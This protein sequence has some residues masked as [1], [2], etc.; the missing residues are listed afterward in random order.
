MR[1]ITVL[2]LLLICLVGLF[3]VTNSPNSAS[4]GFQTM[5]KGLKDIK[6]SW[7]GIDRKITVY[8][9]MGEV[10]YEFEGEF[11]IDTDKAGRIVFDADN[12]RIITNM[13]YI[14]VEKN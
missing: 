8:T 1:K 3:A 9:R 2:M 4:A 10:A 5:E 11:D 6:S 14:A 7:F 13:D 12:K